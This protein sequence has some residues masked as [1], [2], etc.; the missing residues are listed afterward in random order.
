MKKKIAIIWFGIFFLFICRALSAQTDHSNS[1]TFDYDVAVFPGSTADKDLVRA[2]LWISHS[3]LQFIKTD[4]TYTARYQ[5]NFEVYPKNKPALITQDTTFAV[6]LK[7]YSDTIKRDAFRRH[8]FQIELAPGKYQFR[9][10][11]VD[12]NSGG[13]MLQN[14]KKKVPSFSGDKIV[15]SD[16]LLLKSD[17]MDFNAENVLPPNRIHIQD[18]IFIY[19]QA[20]VPPNI[21]KVNLAVYRKQRKEVLLVEKGLPHD[22]SLLMD[23]FIPWKKEQ[24]VRG[25][26]QLVLQLSGRG[27]RQK[28]IKNLFFYGSI[29]TLS[30]ESLDAQVKQMRYIATGKEWDRI[31]KAKGDERQILFKEFW[32]KRDPSPGTPGNEL[33]DEYYKRVRTA[34]EQ[35]GD[36][37]TEGWRTD[38]GH[39]FIIYGPPDQVQKSDEGMD[40]PGNYI[41]WYY[42]KLDRKFVFLDEQGFGNYRLVSGF[43][44]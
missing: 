23:I 20:F 11:V 35:F 13:I 37:G 9:L 34:N 33:F 22:S 10:R 3:D 6:H 21:G 31:S 24:M 43:I 25:R 8:Q 2:F 18:Q 12:L 29:N 38:R 40:Q 39:V 44:D 17:D 42:Q 26:C 30:D 7:K 5:I 41:V 1:K 36:V 28:E 27:R 32:D 19:A 14:V 16:I 15:L 4:S